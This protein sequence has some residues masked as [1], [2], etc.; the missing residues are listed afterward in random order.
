M[1]RALTSAL[2][3]MTETSRGEAQRHARECGGKL[4]DQVGVEHMGH[5]AC[6][7]LQLLQGHWCWQGRR[8]ER[9]AGTGADCA[10]R[11]A[12]AR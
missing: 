9:L 7:Q 2:S 12:G 10:G 6:T 8:I 1:L 4:V 11:G 5:H 3:S